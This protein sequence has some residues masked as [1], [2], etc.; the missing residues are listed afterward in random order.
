MCSYVSLKSLQPGLLIDLSNA[1]SCF[2]FFGATTKVDISC[3]R[4]EM[5]GQHKYSESLLK[6]GTNKRRCFGH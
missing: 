5:D 3:I 2:R 1:L 4:M 6:M